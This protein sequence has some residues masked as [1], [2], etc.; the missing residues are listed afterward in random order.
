MR[1]FKIYLI[2]T[3]YAGVTLVKTVTVAQPKLL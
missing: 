1:G 3:F 2:L